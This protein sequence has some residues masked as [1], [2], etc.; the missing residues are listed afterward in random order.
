MSKLKRRANFG[1]KH[2]D[3]EDSNLVS[4]VYYDIKGNTLDAVF[5]NGNRYRYQGVTPVVFCEFVLASSMGKFYN[6]KIKNRYPSE[7]IR[8]R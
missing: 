1:K 7:K 8:I 3:V 5:H 2:I 4:K 6:K